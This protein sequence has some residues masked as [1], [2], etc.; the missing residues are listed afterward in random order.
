[1]TDAL[2]PGRSG[3][4]FLSAVAS[5]KAEGPP[6]A[7][8]AKAPPLRSDVLLGQAYYLRFD[9][10]LWQ[11]QQPFAPLGTLYA[12]SYL[13]DRGL[14]VALFDAMLA[15]SES[16][17]AAA[18]DRER[19]RVAA[20]Y[21]DSFNYLTKMCLLRMR[22]AALTMI[23]HAR[24]RGCPIVVSGSDATDHP[25]TYLEAGARAV[26]LAE[27]EVTLA[28]LV[29][30]MTR[31]EPID[32]VPGIA[33]LRPDN[34]VVR[35]P[36][37]PLIR[38]LDDLPFPAWDL[39]DV[40]RYRSIWRDRHGYHAMNVVTTRGCPYH[41]NWCAKPIYGQRYGVRSAV[42]VVSE[43]EWLQR[44]FHPDYIAMAD[45][46]FGLQPGWIETFAREVRRAEVRVPFR[47]L[48][49]ADQITA[50]VSESLASAGCRMVWMGAE[51][52]SQRI[53]D[54]MEKGVR[55]EQIREAARLLHSRG[56]GL[57]L[58][59]QFGYPGEMWEDIE[60]TRQL[61]RDT[62]PEDIGISVSYPLPGTKFYDRVRAELGQKQNWFDSND[63]AM[64][65]RATYA[66]EFYRQ[67]HRVVHHEFRAVRQ[68]RV[69]G[70][71]AQSPLSARPADLRR[72][73][74]WLYNRAALPVAARRL[75]GVADQHQQAA[76]PAELIPMLTR[77]AA[78]I[79]TEQDVSS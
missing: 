17:W 8:G 49:R 66:P 48:M 27:G 50:E 32:N 73:A 28:D 9:P 21:E 34:V 4:P 65:Y 25:E 67:L 70:R 44:E 47:C 26:I 30:V 14:K 39:V 29:N 31:G 75:R 5:A 6:S 59:L 20:I 23:G 56:I 57:G 24:A 15:R 64:M 10:K 18:L 33:Y 45:D 63:L 40:D 61:V 68:K 76:A 37:R 58:F 60:A 38:N 41:C 62:A 35:T 46:V 43:M 71:L 12:A 69:L 13:R 54:A 74:S 79:P 16:E 1:M 51:S 7:G 22:Q 36:A 42:N 53:L 55:V 52:G 2:T 11:A 78:A 77:R 72:A 3:G 19:P